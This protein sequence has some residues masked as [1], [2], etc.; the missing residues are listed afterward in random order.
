MIQ[1]A[2]TL[3][4]LRASSVLRRVGLGLAL[5]GSRRVGERPRG[6]GYR[7]PVEHAP[8]AIRLLHELVSVDLSV[9]IG[10][11]VAQCLAAGECVRDSLS[12]LDA[13]LTPAVPMLSRL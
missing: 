9:W 12:A 11:R 2:S 4:S 1:T 5:Q 6:K 13:L 7:H 8:N 3:T 10:V